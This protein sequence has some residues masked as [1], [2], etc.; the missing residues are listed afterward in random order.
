MKRLKIFYLVL[1]IVIVYS[2][3]AYCGDLSKQEITKNKEKI[4][5][6]YDGGVNKF[7]KWGADIK[8]VPWLVFDKE[9]P[10]E[11]RLKTY[12]D[13]KSSE[14]IE[15][16]TRMIGMP[17]M[18]VSYLFCEDKFCG[19]EEDG[20]T[21]KDVEELNNFLYGHW[22]HLENLPRPYFGRLWR[23]GN[24]DISLIGSM[25]ESWGQVFINYMPLAKKFMPNVR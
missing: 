13:P 15:K 9:D 7:I 8:S 17:N 12:I 3:Q 14:E 16:I 24:V 22:T 21:F 4:Q 25:G 20:L 6:G 1:M 18:K 5:R 11:P 2:H 10:T 23:I 19:V